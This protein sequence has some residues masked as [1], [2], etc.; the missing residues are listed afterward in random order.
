MALE[1][2]SGFAREESALRY[3]LNK[4]PIFRPHA[5]ERQWLLDS[6]VLLPAAGLVLKFKYS[7]NGPA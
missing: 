7:N 1:P 6:I 3:A 5:F 4:F 2:P